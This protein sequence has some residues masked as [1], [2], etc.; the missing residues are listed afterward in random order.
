MSKRLDDLQEQLHDLDKRI[1]LAEAAYEKARKT[2][3]RYEGPASHPMWAK[4]RQEV[5]DTH[6][7]CRVLQALWHRTKADLLD[8]LNIEKV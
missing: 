4:L 7:H 3:S 1:E 8:R 5:D 6:T 2:F